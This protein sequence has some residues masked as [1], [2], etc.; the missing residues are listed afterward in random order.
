M[1]IMN[2]NKL[3]KRVKKAKKRDVKD[4]LKD[5]KQTII[6]AADYGVNK[7]NKDIRFTENVEWLK[8]KGFKI[9]KGECSYSSCRI[10]WEDC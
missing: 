8:K 7:V 5:I 2:A 3:A 4:E 10:S 6:S 9:E 1:V